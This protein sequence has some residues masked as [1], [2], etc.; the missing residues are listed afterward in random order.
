MNDDARMNIK[1][2]NGKNFLGFALMEVRTMFRS[3]ES[4][5]KK[6]QESSIFIN[7]NDITTLDCECIVNAAGKSL[8]GGGGVDG[9]I[10]RAAGP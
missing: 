8:L 5:Q 6:H 3:Q 4:V 1:K 10:H 7:Q 9:A 2:W